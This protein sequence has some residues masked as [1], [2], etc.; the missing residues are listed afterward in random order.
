MTTPTI[1]E[2]LARTYTFMTKADSEEGEWVIV[3]PDLPG[4]VTQAETWEEIGEMAQDAMSAFGR[5]MR[6]AEPATGGRTRAWSRKRF[7]RSKAGTTI[8][9]AELLHSHHRCD[10]RARPY[11]S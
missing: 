2:V 10:R 1:E 3:F 8:R 11:H 5:G 6:L 7:R 9:E 4:V